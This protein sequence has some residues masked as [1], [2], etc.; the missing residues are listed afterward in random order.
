[1]SD[2]LTVLGKAP[3]TLSAPTERLFL[4]YETWPGSRSFRV[5]PWFGVKAE[6]HTGTNDAI[7]TAEIVLSLGRSPETH[8]DFPYANEVRDWQVL[9]GTNAP[10]NVW[11]LLLG[12]RRVQIRTARAAVQED[13][14]AFDG[15][16]DK[17][18][19]GWSGS[20]RD[21]A[22][23]AHIY[24]TSTI[25]AADREK[26]QFLV[27]QW[28]RSRRAVLG[29]AGGEDH[30]D[31]EYRRECICVTALPCIFNPGGQPNCDPDPIELG[32]EGGPRVYIF[33]DTTNP[34]A[35]H[36]TVARILRYLQWAGYQ[37]ALPTGSNGLDER[38][39]ARLEL[40]NTMQWTSCDLRHGNL[41]KLVNPYLTP[42]A[43]DS[44][45]TTPARDRVMRMALTDVAVHA[46][47]VLEAFVYVTDRAGMLCRVETAVAPD[48]GADVL[49]SL[50]WSI[51]GDR[52]DVN[53]R[54]AEDRGHLLVGGSGGDLGG[55]VPE[56]ENP[57][58]GSSNP[59]TSRGVYLWVPS[60][61]S[62]DGSQTPAEIFAAANTTEGSLLADES[63]TRPGVLLI[64]AATQFECMAQ[65]K[66]GWP[67]RAEWDV[68]PDDED[69]VAN[70]LQ[71]LAT[72]E[73]RERFV[74]SSMAREHFGSTRNVGRY[75][76]WNEDAAFTAE[77]YQRAAGPWS[78]EEDWEPPRFFTDVAYKEL[79]R[80]GDDG[81]TIRPRRFLPTRAEARATS[82]LPPVA[83]GLVV[84][85]SFDGGATWHFCSAPVTVEAERCALFFDSD[86]L[87]EI[88][89]EI[90]GYDFAQ[91]YIKGVL[92]VRVIANIEADDCLL[93]PVTPSGAC[94]VNR[95]WWELIDRGKQA[96]R[97][98]RFVGDSWEWGWTTGP[99][100]NSPL[101][102]PNTEDDGWHALLPN[103]DDPADR[104]GEQARRYQ[105]DLELRRHSGQVTIPWLWRDGEGP[106][107]GYRIGDELLGIQTGDQ[108][109]FLDMTGS[110]LHHWAAPRVI[111]ISYTYSDEPDEQST[112]LRIENRVYGL[113]D[114][115]GDP[116]VGSGASSG[117]AGQGGGA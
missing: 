40:M 70:A 82:Q 115:V 3:T 33:T 93:E 76:A 94:P 28:R 27:G 116:T 95:N 59:V 69:A 74:R 84:Q 7:P 113:E 8:P 2:A 60:D 79:T 89:D 31:W 14:V 41:D 100:A 109:T 24:A 117:V 43:Y 104:M 81:W 49:T 92:R 37:P 52:S 36:W 55:L 35:V 111:G 107:A 17:L 67:P 58:P 65:L 57:S 96:T 98:M 86:D 78:A 50:F 18:E 13:W 63:Q 106:R 61:N 102:R 112:T 6:W 88:Y 21:H 26:N 77:N 11:Q 97:K 46:M 83:L 16:I 99:I 80:R 12:G 4:F 32:S 101:C 103:N 73:Y 10:I 54:A 5:A 71:A 1:M 51:R 85:L 23:W 34:R 22:R 72:A 9:D 90:T 39:V 56:G 45:L 87:R 108:D 20:G 64:G 47:S 42:G 29:L 25:V 19:L 68:D 38:R 114:V 75:W 44:N 62:D 30:D 110:F 48:A 91:A 66:P 53:P 105:R 15:Y